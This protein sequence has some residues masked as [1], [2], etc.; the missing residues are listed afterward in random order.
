VII[1]RHSERWLAQ[2]LGVARE[3]LCIL[4]ANP[5]HHY[6]SFVIQ[7]TGKKPRQIDNPDDDLKTVQRA[8]R[9]RLLASLPLPG[10]VHGCVRGRSPLTNAKVHR[11]Q[12]NVASVDIKS[13]YPTVT[14]SAIYELWLRLGYGPRL[15]SMLTRLTTL[16][17]HLPQGA[18]TSDALANHVLAPV[19]DGLVAIGAALDLKLSRYLDNIDMSGRRTREAIPLII[20]LLNE[21]GYAVRHKKTFNAGPRSARVVTGYTVNNARAPSVA[22]PEQRRIRSAAHELI[23]EHGAGRQT[24]QLARRLRGR[25]IHLRQTNPGAAAAI[26]RQLAA[27]DIRL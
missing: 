7:P 25:V 21:H 14:N 4:A 12:P 22:R 11:G 26:E 24:F 6:R 1:E 19:D 18:P 13:F 3:L 23:R 20:A 16:A 10:H 27:A 15:G 5:E 8:I 9:V 2:K 17:G